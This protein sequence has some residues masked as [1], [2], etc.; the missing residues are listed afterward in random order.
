VGGFMGY[1][2]MGLVLGYILRRGYGS[3]WMDDEMRYDDVFL[4]ALGLD[5]W[6]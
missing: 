4:F 1:C 3:G 5:I 6:F 2:L